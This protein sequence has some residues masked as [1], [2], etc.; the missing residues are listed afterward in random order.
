MDATFPDFV[1]ALPPVDTAVA[2]LR[3][4][5]LVGAGIV[6]LFMQADRD[7]V[8]PPH[9]H[10]AQW[11]CVLAGC[12][13][14]TIAGYPRTCGRGDTLLLPAEVEHE[15]ALQAG[16]RAVYYCLPDE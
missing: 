15:T 13:R 9:R 2:G 3:G 6:T 12:M 5:Q 8:I 11:C 10:G 4:W 14:V 1:R 16:W 7:V